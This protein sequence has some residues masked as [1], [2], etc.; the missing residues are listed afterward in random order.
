MGI[1]ISKVDELS[2]VG[3]E[4]MLIYLWLHEPCAKQRAGSPRNRPTNDLESQ[5]RA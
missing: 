5:R 4:V 2:I 1:G 3:M